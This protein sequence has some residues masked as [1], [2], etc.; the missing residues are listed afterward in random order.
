MKKAAHSIDLN[1]NTSGKDDL[2]DLS[3]T[4]WPINN[5]NKSNQKENISSRGLAS[6]Q[7]ESLKYGELIV[8][9]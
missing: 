2:I 4:K 3:D 7:R 6:V 5:V 9:G 1:N 8:L